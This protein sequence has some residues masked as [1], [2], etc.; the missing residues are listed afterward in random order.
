MT[1]PDILKVNN[2]L[3]PPPMAYSVEYNDLD[4][5]DTGRSENGMLHRVRVR[6]GIAKIKVGWEQLT[7][8]QVNTIL[9]AVEPASLTVIYYFGSAK[10]ATMYAGDKSLQLLRVNNNKAKWNLSF[11][12]IE[13]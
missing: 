7:T 3:L 12:L 6:S 8:D 11:D 4:S 2:T 5:N 13:F 10:T 9:T 1:G